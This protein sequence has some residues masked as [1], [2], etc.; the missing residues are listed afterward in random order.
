M[1]RCGHAAEGLGE[2]ST[3]LHFQRL[4]LTKDEKGAEVNQSHFNGL[5]SKH[6][7]LKRSIFR[8]FIKENTGAK[9]Y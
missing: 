9:L 4:A 1:G 5:A 7:K 3:N 2:A 8:G 6:L